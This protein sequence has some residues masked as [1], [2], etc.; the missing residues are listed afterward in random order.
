MAKVRSKG[1]MR[2]SSAMAHVDD[3]LAKEKAVKEARKAQ[4]NMPF[5]V[6]VPPGDTKEVIVL[7]DKP[8]FFM[9]EHQIQNP[10]TKKWDTF[11]GCTKAFDA[12]PVCEETGKESYYAMFLSVID[13]TPYTDRQGKTHRFSRKLMMVKNLSQQKKF[14]RRYEK[15]GTLRGYMLELN[16]DS[17]KDPTI[18]GDI[19]FV[20]IMEEADLVK[21]K[22]KYKDREGKVHSEDCSVPFVYEELFEEPDSDK[23]RSI[24][25]GSPVPG[26]S[27]ANSALMEDD[28]EWGDEDEEDDEDEAPVR[29]SSKAVKRPAKKAAVVEDEEEDEEDEDEVAED[30]EDTPWDDDEEEAEDEEDEDE[31]PAPRAKRK[32]SV[33]KKEAPVKSGR[34]KLRGSLR[35][36]G[37]RR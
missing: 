6:W 24:V 36:G 22:R 31:E 14:I 25:G 15:D 32:P 37:T 30:E 5:R 2:G 34:P 12:C 29:K 11:L 3:E 35:R 7:D 20:E 16:R 23:L 13:L 26:S 27:K 19:E 1:F 10:R 18:G 9:Y 28:D 8:D 4:S 33:A 21:Y 17:D